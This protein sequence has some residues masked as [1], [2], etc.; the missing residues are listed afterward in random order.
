MRT[1]PFVALLFSLLAGPGDA[2]RAQNDPLIEDIIQAVSQTRLA[3]DVQTLQDF[4]T[5]KTLTQGNLDA[6]DWLYDTLEGLGLEVERHPFSWLSSSA[7]NII[8]RIPGRVSP[9][10]IVAITGHFDSTSEIP[11][12]LAPG[13]DDAASV[14]AGVLE[15]ARLLRE[16]QFERTIE[17]QCFNAEEQGRRGSIA[18]ASDY[19][20][21]GK[22]II[23]VINADMIGYW[24][25]GWQ[26]D[27]DVVHEPGSRWLANRV[28]AVAAQYVG[29]PT[30]RHRTGTCRDDHVSFSDHG[31]S[32]ISTM[33]CW[34]A[35]NGGN[36]ST[37]HYHRSTDTLSTLNLDCMKQVV[38][39]N[40]ASVADLAVPI[41]LSTDRATFSA[42]MGG[43]VGLTLSAGP[44]HAQRPYF[45][46]GS[47]TGSDPG[48]SLPGGL[49]LPLNWDGFSVLAFGQANDQNFVR[50]SDTLDGAGWATS[51]FLVPPGALLG[52]GNQLSFTY[53]FVLA[54][55]VDFVSTPV[56]ID[57]TP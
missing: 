50:F 8:A 38:Q 9:D 13:A 42:A 25:T 39:V 6:G 55:P 49:M 52:W 18:I 29:I 54:D 28:I 17:F 48:T 33:D 22:N 26:R 31:F 10:E 23:G 7:E 36:E 41:S 1:L 3:D 19:Q 15:A 46:L 53:A 34:D 51:T 2:A 30:A 45:V 56:Q 57:V 35:H 12:T 27:L 32:A 47:V 44:G 24:P 4:G 21:A 40:I 5:R 43:A 16:Y 37:P 11:N 20:A 14:I